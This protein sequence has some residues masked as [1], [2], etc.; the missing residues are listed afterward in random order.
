MPADAWD[1]WHRYRKAKSGKGWTDDAARLSLRKLSQLRD[2]GNDPVAVIDQSIERT[3]AGLFPVKDDRA[4]QQTAGRTAGHRQ[5][6]AERNQA[7]FERLM[8]SESGTIDGDIREIDD[9]QE[10][11]AWQP[12][13]A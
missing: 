8:G 13:K 7:E 12:E 3:W 10:A 6:L 9:R 5:T 2:E 11:L 4:R 1:R